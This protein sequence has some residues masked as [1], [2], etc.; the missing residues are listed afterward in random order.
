LSSRIDDAGVAQPRN[1][2]ES[3]WIS[4]S[5]Q[6]YGKISVGDGSSLWYN[7]VARAEC[8]E[9]TIGRMTNVQDFVMIHVGYEDATHVG[10]FCSITHHATL[11]GCTIGDACLVGINAVIM[12]GAIIGE[13]SIV[14][15]SAMVI[16]GKVFPPHSIIAGVPARVIGERDCTRANRMNAWLYNYNAGAHRRGEY[17]AWEGPEFETWRAAKQAAVDADRDL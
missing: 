3:A 9:I 6:I 2:H 14:A 4:P 7:V 16:E 15:G 8:Q 13:G 12:D 5:A 10:D 11:H 1:I 17:R